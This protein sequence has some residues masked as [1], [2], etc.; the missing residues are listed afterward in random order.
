MRLYKDKKTPLI[1]SNGDSLIANGD[2]LETLDASDI[3]LTLSVSNK[4][5]N[6][7]QPSQAFQSGIKPAICG[8]K[9]L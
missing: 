9:T 5:E 2:P 3:Q 6:L 8:L 1:G 4:Q 7:S